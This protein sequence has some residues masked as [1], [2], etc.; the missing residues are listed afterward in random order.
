MKLQIRDVFT[1]NTADYAQ[2]N[3]KGEVDMSKAI[4][5]FERQYNTTQPE[6]ANG[7]NEARIIMEGLAKGKRGCG[8]YATA[9]AIRETDKRRTR[10]PSRRSG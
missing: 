4:G 1:G 7:F 9:E 6:Q 2:R 10:Q 3:E 8:D 5:M